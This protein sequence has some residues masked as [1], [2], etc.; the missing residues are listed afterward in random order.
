M[1]ETHQKS[2]GYG[3]LSMKEISDLEHKELAI[4]VDILEDIIINLLSTLSER[5]KE[6]EN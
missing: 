4:K 5:E 3:F 6:N 1:K 2:R